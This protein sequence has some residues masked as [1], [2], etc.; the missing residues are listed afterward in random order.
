MTHTDKTPEVGTL[1]ELNV[2]PGDVVECVHWDGY[3]FQEGQRATVTD[4]L[5]VYGSLDFP[6]A[7]YV[8]KFRIIS[9]A[10]ADSDGLEYQ[11][12]NA[13]LPKL[14]YGHARLPSG[15]VIDLTAIT[16]PF[17]LLDEVYGLGAQQALRDHGGPYEAWQVEGYWEAMTPGWGLAVTY[18]V[19]SQPPEP[20]RE[21]VKRSLHGEKFMGYVAIDLVDGEPDWSTMRKWK[22]SDALHPTHQ[23]RRHDRSARSAAH[24]PA[25]RAEIIRAIIIDAYHKEAENN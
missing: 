14:P 2:K 15:E 8:G 6:A 5:E 24:Y 4:D 12:Q 13:P 21:T 20:V 25:R 19:R 16:A 23:N 10:A 11:R 1:R 9:R 17:G 22:P 3:M 18:R 7:H